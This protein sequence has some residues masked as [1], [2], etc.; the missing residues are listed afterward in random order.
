MSSA[1]RKD[2]VFDLIGKIRQARGCCGQ[3]RD[4]AHTHQRVRPPSRGRTGAAE[5]SMRSKSNALVQAPMGTSVNRGCAG[6]PSQVPLSRSFTRPV[7]TNLATGL[8]TTLPTTLKGR[9]RSSAQVNDSS[10]RLDR[11]ASGRCELLPMPHSTT[12]GSTP[13]KDCCVHISG[14]GLADIMLRSD[15][16]SEFGEAA[17]AD[18][19]ARHQGR[20][21]CGRGGGSARTRAQS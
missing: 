19:W 4:H 11:A 16:N 1:Y 15:G 5:I 10:R 12:E 13:H 3:S 2:G 8:P 9:E 18:A 7:P 20:V 14:P 6:W 17:G 21:R